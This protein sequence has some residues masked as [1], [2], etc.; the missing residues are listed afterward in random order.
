MPNS[1]RARSRAL[2]LA[3]GAL[4]AGGLAALSH[5]PAV[6]APDVRHDLG[7]A[8][9]ADGSVSRVIQGQY[10]VVMKDN[11]SVAATRD[12]RRDAVQHGGDILFDYS[13]ALDGFAARLPDRALQALENNPR[14][15]YV[16][17]DRTVTALGDQYDP[18][19]GLDRIDQRARPLNRSYH[20]DRTGAGVNAYI[21]DSG[22]RRTHAQFGT[23]ASH[24]FSSIPDGNGSLDCNGHGTHVA[25]TVGA[26][27]YGVAKAVRLVAVRV[28]DCEGSGSFAGVIAGI[29]WVTGDHDP[30]EP[31]VANMSLGGGFSSAV[32]DAVANSIADGVSYVVAAGN[33]NVDACTASPASAPDALTVGATT[34]N[35]ARASYSNWGTCLDLFAPGS[36]VLSTY[37]VSNSSVHIE[38]GTSMASPHV[39]GVVA[40]YLQQFP[41]ASPATTANAIRN[42]ATPNRVTGIGTGSPNKLLYSK[43]SSTI[44]SPPPP[45]STNKVAQPGFES[46]PGIWQGQEWTIDCDA[47]PP[48]PRSGLCHAVLGDEGFS[49]TEQLSQRGIVVPAG[50]PVLQFYTRIT[51]D[52]F[53]TTPFDRLQVRVVAGGTSTTVMT[54][55]NANASAGYVLRSASMAAFAGQTVEL[56]FVGVEDWAV[57]T[58]FLIDDV[59]VS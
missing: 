25:G 7:R 29:D 34:Y 45:A 58:A 49:S 50:S 10:I 57:A 30:G 3:A 20:Y 9:S 59:S 40:T 18:P 26:A 17:A 4:V 44:T 33:S 46:G 55:S 48:P 14:V 15:A 56:R 54:L 21:I 6:G 27:K 42:S 1:K 35:D 37:A 31:A 47:G 39:A 32:N 43:F 38:N 52:E 2:R 51:T 11:A 5:D 8:T 24:G 41:N 16:E 28:L 19:W 12:A 13:A 36:Q 53:G 23:R 22:I